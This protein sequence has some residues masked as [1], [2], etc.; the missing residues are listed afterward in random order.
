MQSIFYVRPSA[1]EIVETAVTLREPDPPV[2]LGTVTDDSGKPVSHALAVLYASG[3]VQPDTVA[4]ISCTDA[5]GRFFFGP[6]EAGVLYEIFF[7]FF[8]L[9]ETISASCASNSSK[10][11]A[12]R[13]PSTR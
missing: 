6:L 3:G 11:M 10:L 2:L 9:V 4:G 7:Y 5:Q 8:A 13:S 1:Q 12:P